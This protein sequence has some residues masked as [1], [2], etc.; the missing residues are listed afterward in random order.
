MNFPM[1]NPCFANFCNLAS[2]FNSLII[3]ETRLAPKET[4]LESSD[5]VTVGL[6]LIALKPFFL[7]KKMLN[8]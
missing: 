6:F 1:T 4:I 7:T 8:Q 5:I 3:I 2:F